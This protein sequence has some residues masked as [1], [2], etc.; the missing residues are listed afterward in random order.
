MINAAIV[1]LGWW[2]KTLVESVQED[3]DIIKF[4]AGSTRKASDDVLDFCKQ[5]DLTHYTDFDEVL[6]DSSVDAVV[7]AT[8]PVPHHKQILAAAKA[9]KHVFCEKPFTM[10]RKQAEEAV[11]ALDKE[12]LTLGLGYNRRFHP[13]VNDLR[14]RVKSGK[15]GTILHIESTM[16]AP[17]GLFLPPEAWRTQ[18]DQSPCGGLFPMG[19]HAVDAF[20]DLCGEIDEVYA[21]SFHRAVPSEN[22]DTTSILFR[23]KDGMSGYLGTMMATAGS[24]RQQIYGTEGWAELIGKTHSKDQSS[25]E[26]RKGLF[27]SYTIQPVK[28]ERENLDAPLFDGNKAELEAFGAAADGGDPY[29]ITTDEMIHGVAVTEAIIKSAGSNKPVKVE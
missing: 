16:S 4:V 13:C 25:E 2:G 6:K 1:G 28:G 11:A 9:G 21:M 12:G 26:R 18:P 3:S 7:L 24:F 19:V 17:N 8:P 5:Y 23:M 27:G 15:L 22:D 20:I 10:T 29:P 14:D